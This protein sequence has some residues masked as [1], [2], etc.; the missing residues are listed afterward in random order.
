[1][2]LIDVD[3]VITA[4]DRHTNDDGT[5]DDDISVILEEVP[6]AEK[7]GMWIKGTYTICSCCGAF[8]FLSNGTKYCHEC[9]ALMSESLLMAKLGKDFAE[10]FY[11]GLTE[12]KNDK[13]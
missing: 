6:S 12:E 10:S 3:A 1:M 2:R 13:S 4:V 11:K 7:I 5:L 8:S 9:G